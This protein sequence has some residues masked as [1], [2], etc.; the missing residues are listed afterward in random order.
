MNKILKYSM[1]IGVSF[2]LTGCMG[3]MVTGMG[4]MFGKMRSNIMQTESSTVD[5]ENPS[6]KSY[7]IAVR[8]CTQC[9]EMKKKALHTPK[10]W[11]KT[12]ERMLIHMKQ[13]KKLQPDEYELI[14]IEHYYGVNTMDSK[15]K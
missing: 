1:A 7:V 8:Y 14:M 2:W 15:T 11:D 3:M 12:I 10:D 4:G 6:S 13:Q 9:H 5:Q